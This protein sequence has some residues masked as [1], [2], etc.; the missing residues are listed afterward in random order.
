[1]S[2]GTRQHH[3]LAAGHGLHG[4][5]GYAHE[6]VGL[7]Q[8]LRNIRSGTQH[9]DVPAADLRVGFLRQCFEITQHV[10][11]ADEDQAGIGMS[12]H[13]LRHGLRQTEGV[14][15]HGPIHAG[16]ADDLVPLAHLGQGIVCG[17]AV[18]LIDI[19]AVDGDADLV[20]FPSVHVDQILL[21]ILRHRQHSLAGAGQHLQIPYGIEGVMEG[22]HEGNI[23]LLRQ[24]VCDHAGDPRVG[25][26]HPGLFLTDNAL[27]DPTGFQKGQRILFVQRRRYVADAAFCQRVHKHAALGYHRHLVTQAA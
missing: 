15:G 6:Y 10:A 19:N 13:N 5:T 16:D 4:G 7:G 3:R 12:R 24:R 2:L 14:M 26:D 25:M 23:V 1:M 20:R 17:G 9:E 11:A 8:D 27:D 18:E 22:G 21:Q